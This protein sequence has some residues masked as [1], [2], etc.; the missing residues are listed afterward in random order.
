MGRW[1]HNGSWCRA[2]FPI[3]ALLASFVG[4]EI[5]IV[6]TRAPVRSYSSVSVSSASGRLEP[7]AMST[8]PVGNKVAVCEPRGVCSMSLSF[9]VFPRKDVFPF[10]AQSFKVRR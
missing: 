3:E 5:V 8:L 6:V 1:T 9:Q 4:A 2:V 10:C 7:L